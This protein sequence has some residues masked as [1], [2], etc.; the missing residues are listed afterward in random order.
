MIRR[1]P[2]AS[3]QRQ[4]RCEDNA[5]AGQAPKESFMQQLLICTSNTASIR[6][7]Y[8]EQ[9]KMITLVLS[10]QSSSEAGIS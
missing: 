2:A 5:S 9:T 6:T 7:V 3:S 10:N 1:L 8:N 4:H